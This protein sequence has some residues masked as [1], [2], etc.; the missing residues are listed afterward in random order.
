MNETGEEAETERGT[1]K[2]EQDKE[3]ALRRK[4]NRHKGLGWIIVEQPQ[5]WFV[6]GKSGR[7]WET[8]ASPSSREWTC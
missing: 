7:D 5:A 8:Q 1:E 4:K 2:Q 6:G 3:E